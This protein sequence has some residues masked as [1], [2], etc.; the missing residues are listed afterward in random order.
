LGAPRMTLE[1]KSNARQHA[2]RTPMPPLPA[3]LDDEWEEF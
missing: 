2:R 1:D 3:T